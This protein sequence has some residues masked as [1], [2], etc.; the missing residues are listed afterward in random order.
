MSNLIATYFAYEVV[1]KITA[2]TL[3]PF[4]MYHFFAKRATIRNGELRMVSSAKLHHPVEWTRQC[5]WMLNA[6]NSN[7]SVNRCETCQTTP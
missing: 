5:A 6:K 1:S 4:E 2:A 3:W 7:S